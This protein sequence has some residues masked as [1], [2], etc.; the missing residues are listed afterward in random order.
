MDISVSHLLR[1]PIG[2]RQT[3]QIDEELDGVDVAGPVEGEVTL[4]RTNRGI[5]ASARLHAEAE[6][7]CGRCLELFDCPLDLRFEEEYFPSTDIISGA[8]LAIPDEPGC[9]TIDEHHILDLTEA[10][11]QYALLAIPMKPLCREKCAG[12]CAGCGCNLNLETCH[13]STQKTDP[14]WAQLT[15]L[16]NKRKGTDR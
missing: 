15:A 12:L 8:P 7:N 10:I 1:S 13:C 3:H 5:L 9:F 2:T 16:V 14:R 4:T 11:R 6:V